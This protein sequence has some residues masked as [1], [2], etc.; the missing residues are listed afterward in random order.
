[1]YNQAG[2]SVTLQLIIVVKTMK[3]TTNIVGNDLFSQSSGEVLFMNKKRIGKWTRVNQRK[4]KQLEFEIESLSRQSRSLHV[5]TKSVLKKFVILNNKMIK[6]ENKINSINAKH[7]LNLP[8][9]E[10]NYEYF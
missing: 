1:M 8:T 3:K 10:M 6:R 5:N 9:N 4:V 7:G 2:I